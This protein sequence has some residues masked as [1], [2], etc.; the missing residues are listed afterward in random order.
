MT[1]EP[2]QAYPTPVFWSLLLHIS[3][4]DI[5]PLLL[6]S[7]TITSLLNTTL[8]HPSGYCQTMIMSSHWIQHS[9]TT[10]Y[11]VYSIPQILHWPM[12]VCILLIASILSCLLNN[13][14]ACSVHHIKIDHHQESLHWSSND[15]LPSP[16]VACWLTDIQRLMSKQRSPDQILIQLLSILSFY[17]GL[18]PGSLTASTCISNLAPWWPSSSSDQA[19]R[20]QVQNCSITALENIPNRTWSWPPSLSANL[21]LYHLQAW[22]IL[23]SQ[24]QL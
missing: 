5:N 15:K 9:L 13:M 22:T 10:T 6:M 21:L 3:L 19:L 8:C 14:A 18:P 23:H 12:I 20:G 11:P 1:S 24:L 4:I 2:Y 17:A 16:M 7:T